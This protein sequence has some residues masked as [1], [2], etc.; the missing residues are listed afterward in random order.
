LP[1]LVGEV[2]CRGTCSKALPDRHP[3]R[4]AFV[5]NSCCDIDAIIKDIIA[6]DDDVADVY[7]D[8]ELELRPI[9]SFLRQFRLNGYRAGHGRLR[10]SQIRPASRPQLF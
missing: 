8:P 2:L 4:F 3:T 1:Q 7:P 9:E 5:L 6:V 10:R